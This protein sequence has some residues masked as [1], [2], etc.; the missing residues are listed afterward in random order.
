MHFQ[1][2]EGRTR[3]ECQFVDKTLWLSQAL[4]AELYGVTVPTVNHHLKEPFSIGELDQKAA[5][6]NSRVVRQEVSRQV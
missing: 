4:M 1:T 2:A 6:R 3:V 5:V